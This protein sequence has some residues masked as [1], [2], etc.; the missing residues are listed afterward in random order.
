MN[1]ADPQDPQSLVAGPAVLAFISALGSA[2]LMSWIWLLSRL[3]SGRA[4][5]PPAAP[6]RRVPWGLGSILAVILLYLFAGQ[7]IAGVFLG[8]TRPPPKPAEIVKAVPATPSPDL[9][10]REKISVVLL[11]NSAMIPLLPALLRAT[12]GARWADLGLSPRGAWIDLARGAVTCL[13]IAPSCYAV[14][15]VALRAWPPQKHPLQDL[16]QSQAVTPALAI[17]AFLSAVVVTPVVEELV[18]RGVLLGWLN[19]LFVAPEPGLA[20][21]ASAQVSPPEEISESRVG[22][23][24]QPWPGLEALERDPALAFTPR[25]LVGALRTL[26]AAWIWPNLVSSAVFALLHYAQW[27]APVPLFLLALALGWL[28]RRT[29]RLWA[30]IAL[31]AGFNGISTTILV[32]TALA[33]PSRQQV[34][35]SPQLAVSAALQAQAVDA[36]LQLP[37][38][39]RNSG[40]SAR[41]CLGLGQ[42]RD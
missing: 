24:S 27:P 7:L 25:A 29:G 12:S 20:S 8:A 3:L 35:Q 18:F 11:L 40:K 33:A 32:L 41:I 39:P 22:S 26:P 4:F 23:A 2:M 1:P 5:L 6:M 30:S 13:I 34:A 15:A 31:H 16:L 14:Y 9:S 17:V 42:G 37:V 38:C 19:Q 10:S 36:G 28:A 21:G